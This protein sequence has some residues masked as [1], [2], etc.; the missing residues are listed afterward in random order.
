MNVR[1]LAVSSI[2]PWPITL[3]GSQLQVSSATWHMASMGL[4]KT[5]RIAFGDWLVASETTERTIPAFVP[6]RSSRV[7]PGFR[8]TPDVTTIT[9][10][11][12]ESDQLFVPRI[13]LEDPVH[14]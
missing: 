4:A 1:Y 3:A 7:I 11:S 10:E 6:R 2:P 8:A 14:G 5:T 9:S 13:L 12:A